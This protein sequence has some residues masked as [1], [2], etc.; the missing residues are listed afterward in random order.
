VIRKVEFQES[1]EIVD[2]KQLEA[3]INKAPHNCHSID[4][5]D[6]IIFITHIFKKYNLFQ[7]LS[8]YEYRYDSGSL[9]L[10]LKI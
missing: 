10:D 5:L 8:D 6:F 4:D 3:G 2:L 9:I 7:K 1:R